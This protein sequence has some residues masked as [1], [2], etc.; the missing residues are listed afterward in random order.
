MAKNYPQL[1]KFSVGCTALQFKK[2]EL[3]SGFG[4]G[5]G[6]F[7]IQAY[8]HSGNVTASEQ[9]YLPDS[10]LNK[11]QIGLLERI[12]INVGINHIGNQYVKEWIFPFKSGVSEEDQAEYWRPEAE[13]IFERIL[14]AKEGLL[15]VVEVKDKKI[16]Q[17]KEELKAKIELLGGEIEDQKEKI[18]GL[19]EEIQRLEEELYSERRTKE[20]IKEILYDSEDPEIDSEGPNDLCSDC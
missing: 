4:F 1:N 19:L 7:T 3:K 11:E 14:A 13:V 5:V 17:E 8:L 12:G 2:V 10:F 18:S 15:V 9:S 20:K 16:E 6:R